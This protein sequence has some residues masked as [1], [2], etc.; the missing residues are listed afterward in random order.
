MLQQWLF[1]VKG[2]GTSD[3]R[4]DF[5]R[6]HKAAEHG[7][8]AAELGYPTIN[9]TA[10]PERVR[11][12]VPELVDVIKL[13]KTVDHHYMKEM[14][15]HQKFYGSSSNAQLER[16]FA[17]PT[18]GFYGIR[19]KDVIEK[20]LLWETSLITAVN[21]SGILNIVSGRTVHEMVLI[22]HA[23]TLLIA[24]DLNV[25]FQQAIEVRETSGILGEILYPDEDDFVSIERM[26]E[27][28]EK[29]QQQALEP[30][31]DA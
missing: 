11:R 6:A 17:T 13:E 2:R 12:L 31:D 20:I 25:S 28:E 27:V 26:Q 5:C 30:V 23:V 18:T 1:K 24:E 10:L 29:E 4:M 16:N 14:G 7:L 8:I 9:W 22:P 3:E 15:W 19:G 21:A